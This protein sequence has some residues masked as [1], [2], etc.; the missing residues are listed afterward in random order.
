MIK[1]N[2]LQLQYLRYREK[3]NEAVLRVMSSGIYLMGLELMAFEKEFSRFIKMKYVVG[4]GSGTD[5]LTLAIKSLGLT[6][7]DEVIVPANCYPT[8]FGVAASGVK[9][10]LCDANEDTLNV[11]VETIKKAF[12]KNTKVV[13]AVHLYGMPAPMK[14]I[15]EF[16]RERKL[17]VIEDC[18]QAVGARINNQHVG[19]FGDV[20]CFSFYP[21]KNLAA[22]GDGGAIVTN[23]KTLADRL[24][25]L[26][27]YGEDVRYH[28]LEMATHSRLDEIQSAILRVRLKKIALELKEREKLANGYRNK[29]PVDL[30]IPKF[31]P[32]NTQHAFHLFVVRTDRVD[33]LRKYLAKREIETRIH[34]PS[35]IHFQ[36]AF[37]YLGYKKGDFPIAEKASK[38]VLS[39]PLYPGMKRKD[40]DYVVVQTIN[41]C[42][43]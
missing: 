28:S 9:I 31:I 26:R 41:S 5:A 21:T 18:A 25:R 20:G 8:V 15:M 33:K 2:D 36:P 35:P 3:L 30:L 38:E 7:S 39:L 10:K 11:S 34:Y 13:I 24:K 37:R 6:G 23:S 4:V 27:M 16:A 40:Q 22:M 32:E 43:L 12:T 29:L 1:P 19:T 17:K 14:E 42:K